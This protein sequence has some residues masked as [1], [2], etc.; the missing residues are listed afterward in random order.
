MDKELIK[1]ILELLKNGQEP[2]ANDLGIDNDTLG[3]NVDAA[4]NEGLITGAIVQRGG[5]GSKVVF[6]ILKNAKISL[7]GLDYLEK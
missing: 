1:K 5:I 3:D 4:Q 6:V 2:T 7:K